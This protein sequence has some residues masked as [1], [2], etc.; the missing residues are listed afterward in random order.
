MTGIAQAADAMG[1]ATATPAVLALEAVGTSFVDYL[2]SFVGGHATQNGFRGGSVP[3]ET[4][5]STAMS[6]DLKRRSF[7]FV[8]PT[9]CY[10]FMQATGLVND[11]ASN[12]FRYAEVAALA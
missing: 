10:A 3:A 12:C 2:W 6:K 1:A 7:R 8:G 4:A 9:T 5:E 11:H